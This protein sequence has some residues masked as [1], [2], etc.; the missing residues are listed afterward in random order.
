M[1]FL[2]AQMSVET[3]GFQMLW[4]SLVSKSVVLLLPEIV[5]HIPKKGQK[6]KNMLECL[7]TLKI[8]NISIS[9]HQTNFRDRPTLRACRWRVATLPPCRPL[10]RY[11]H[12]CMPASAAIIAWAHF[13]TR[14][15]ELIELLTVFWL[16]KLHF[17]CQRDATIPSR[18][19]SRFGLPPGPPPQCVLCSFFGRTI[20]KISGGKNIGIPVPDR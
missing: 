12:Y 17:E 2:K 1:I 7:V 20:A 8:K 19:W 15:W 3:V 18:R 9:Y 14:M 6:K 16:I 5:W 4:M 11:W 13:S 10:D